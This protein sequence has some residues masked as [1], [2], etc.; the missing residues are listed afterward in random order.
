MKKIA[1]TIIGLASLAGIT[2]LISAI[3]LLVLQLIQ[4]GSIQD[5]DPLQF[6]IWIVLPTIFA[7][8]LFYRLWKYEGFYDRYRYTINFATGGIIGTVLLVA[9]FFMYLWL[10]KADGMAYLWVIAFSIIGTVASFI[11]SLIGWFIDMKKRKSGV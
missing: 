6:N 9:A 3:Y 5:P 8:F 1:V 7:C 4:L 10:I 11:L 2:S